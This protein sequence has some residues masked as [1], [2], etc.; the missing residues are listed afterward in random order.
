MVHGGMM[1]TEG[2]PTQ[3]QFHIAS[4]KKPCKNQTALSVHHFGGY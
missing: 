1:Y 2:A 3:Q 4:A